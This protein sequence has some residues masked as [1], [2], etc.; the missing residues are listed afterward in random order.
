MEVCA[1]CQTEVDKTTLNNSYGEDQV[2]V[3]RCRDRY[4]CGL[5][6]DAPKRKLMQEERTAH[7]ALLKIVEGRTQEEKL[8]AIY[9]LTMNMLEE[10]GES[11]SGQHYRHR[12]TGK[13][14]I[15]NFEGKWYPL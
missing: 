11:R 1:I 10:S 14:Y 13:Q 4:E 5:R 8:Q 3:R 2:L 9:G 12:E 7:E 15:Y 6:K